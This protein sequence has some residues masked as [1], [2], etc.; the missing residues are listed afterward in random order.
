V[1]RHNHLETSSNVY[2]A[3]IWDVLNPFGQ[4][5]IIICKAKSASGTLFACEN[6]RARSLSCSCKAEI[7]FS[8]IEILLYPPYTPCIAFLYISWSCHAWRPESLMTPK[9]LSIHP[10]EVAAVPGLLQQV[11][12][13]LPMP[14]AL[15]KSPS[16]HVCV[17]DGSM[18]PSIGM[19]PAASGLIIAGQRC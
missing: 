17:R 6:F 3:R 13:H 14:L 16:T 10:T 2:Q 9:D 5:A 8:E 18:N 4:V 19:M 7:V 11:H 1:P 15:T 12:L